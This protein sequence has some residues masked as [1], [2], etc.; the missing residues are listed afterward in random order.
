MAM[1]RWMMATVAVAFV[2]PVHAQDPRYRA[3]AAAQPAPQAITD[4]LTTVYRVSG[5]RDDGSATDNTGVAT[6]FSCSTNS[7]A[8]ERIRVFVRGSGGTIVGDLTATASAR[9]TLTFA[10]HAT[11]AFIENAGSLTTGTVAQGAATIQ[12]TTTNITCSAMIVNAASSVPD[13]VALHMQRFNPLA[14]TQE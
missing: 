2:L 6:V 8:Q 10:T 4:P 13:G 14:G 3:G 7:A 11:A 12:S 5:V 1:H 9:G